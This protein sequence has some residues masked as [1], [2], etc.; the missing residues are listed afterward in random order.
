VPIQDQRGEARYPLQA[1]AEAGA[2]ERGQED[3]LNDIH[4]DKTAGPMK[5]LLGEGV[6]MPAPEYVEQSVGSHRGEDTLRR[7]RGSAC[8]C[9]IA[10]C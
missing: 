10:C 5:R 9:A 4:R 7:V 3:L 6:R 2:G 8:E 1:A